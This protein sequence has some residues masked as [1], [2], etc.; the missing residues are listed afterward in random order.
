M[1]VIPT[2]SSG[3]SISPGG[4]VFTYTANPQAYVTS[5]T[6]WF[7]QKEVRNRC[8]QWGGRTCPDSCGNDVPACD[9][10]CWETDWI[11]GV[12]TGNPWTIIGCARESGA[13]P[14]DKDGSAGGT[15]SISGYICRNPS[16]ADYTEEQDEFIDTYS[17]W[18]DDHPK[19]DDR[20]EDYC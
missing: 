2:A 18:F 6:H 17:N 13:Y 7:S 4:H 1:D 10:M 15:D 14:F 16:T 19:Y 11:C 3:L 20:H 9:W 12:G 5:T 8:E